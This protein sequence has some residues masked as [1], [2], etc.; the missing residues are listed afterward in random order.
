MWVKV[1]R[2]SPV[3]PPCSWHYRGLG[4][5]TGAK[6]WRPRTREPLL[7]QSGVA[8]TSHCC[9]K[10]RLQGGISS[11]GGSSAVCLEPA[12]SE[13]RGGEPLPGLLKRQ[14]SC[15]GLEVRHRCITTCKRVNHTELYLFDKNHMALI[16]NV[17]DRSWYPI[18]ILIFW[19]IVIFLTVTLSQDDCWYFNRILTPKDI[20]IIIHNVDLI[21]TA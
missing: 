6:R 13:H 4:S 21:A 8:S 9:E 7:G 1:Q 17:K 16:L 20:L 18:Y 11:P 14:Y 19:N 12:T 5:S 2:P 15:Y 10:P 3:S